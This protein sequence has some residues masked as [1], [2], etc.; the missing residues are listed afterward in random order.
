MTARNPRHAETTERRSPEELV[1]SV[2]TKEERL[3]ELL[4][5]LQELLGGNSNAI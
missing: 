1:A 5:E 2:L 4:G 3:T